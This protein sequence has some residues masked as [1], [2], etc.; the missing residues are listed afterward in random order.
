MGKGELTIVSLYP[1]ISAISGDVWTLNDWYSREHLADIKFDRIF[2]VHWSWAK[3]DH[4]GRYKGDWKEECRKSGAEIISLD[5]L[6]GLESTLLDREKL[7]KEFNPEDLSNS[8]AIMIGVAILEGYE[9]IRLTGC[10]MLGGE[11]IHCVHGVMNMI[12]EARNRGVVVEADYEEEWKVNMTKIDWS[13]IEFAMLPY[14]L[15]DKRPPK[16]EIK[17]F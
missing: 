16:I 14:W 4:E 9:F 17:T 13:K 2:Q 10:H 15:R 6:E 11:Y 12:A 7:C 3:V 5:E 8:I 1:K